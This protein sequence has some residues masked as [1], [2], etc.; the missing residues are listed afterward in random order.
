M[1]DTQYYIDGNIVTC[2][3]FNENDVQFMATAQADDGDLPAAMAS[4]L[5]QAEKTRDEYE[6]KED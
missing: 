5:E 6:T 1:K 3:V 4:A 2:T